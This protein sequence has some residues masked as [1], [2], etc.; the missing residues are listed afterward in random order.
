MLLKNVRLK[1]SSKRARNSKVRS[2]LI[3]KSEFFVLGIPTHRLPIC[4]HFFHADDREIMFI[5]E[6]L[7]V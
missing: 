2:A 5:R 1:Y 6:S 4:D 3:L 7:Q